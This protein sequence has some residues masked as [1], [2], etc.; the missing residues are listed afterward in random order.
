[1]PRRLNTSRE[2]H[3][4]IKRR[5]FILIRKKLRKNS[6][7]HH[8]SCY[9]LRLISF[10]TDDEPLRAGKAGPEYYFCGSRQEADRMWREEVAAGRKRPI[11]WRIRCCGQRSPDAPR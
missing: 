2:L 11:T 8:T 3:D 1:M 7:I 6:R 10:A 4:A 9:S 5:G